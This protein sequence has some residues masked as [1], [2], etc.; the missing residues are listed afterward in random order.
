MA[1][2]WPLPSP[3]RRELLEAFSSVIYGAIFVSFGNGSDQNEIM[4]FGSQLVKGEFDN[5]LRYSKMLI[6]IALRS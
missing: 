5:H 3:L 4:G 2:A 6:T 1:P